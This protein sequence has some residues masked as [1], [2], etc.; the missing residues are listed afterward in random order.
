MSAPVVFYMFLNAFAPLIIHDQ[1]LTTLIFDEEVV[2]PHT[3][4]SK[5]QIYLKKSPNSKMIFL[6]SKGVK[7]KTNL[8]V[9]TKSG[10]LYSFLI[11]T[12]SRPHSI[13]QVKDGKK[14]KAFKDVKILRDVVIQE[15]PFMTRVFN[16]SGSKITIN[17]REV[18]PGNKLELPKGSPVFLNKL[19]V[20]R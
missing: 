16:N 12:G 19:R 8:T 18:I 3:G 2:R 6:K 13:V 1:F 15:S 14:G 4:A 11:K 5:H 7:L 17:S 10:K 20:Y 9:P